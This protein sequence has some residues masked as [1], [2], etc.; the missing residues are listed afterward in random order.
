MSA[1]SNTLQIKISKI[2]GIRDS[3]I[4]QTLLRAKISEVWSW[5]RI[6]PSIFLYGKH[7]YMMFMMVMMMMMI[8]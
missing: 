3:P 6:M 4:K 2:N 7:L 8:I 1:F 5:R